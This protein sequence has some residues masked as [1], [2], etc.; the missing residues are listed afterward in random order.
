MRGRRFVAAA[1]A[2]AFLGVGSASGG[3][4]AAFPAKKSTTDPPA[5]TLKPV[6]M[7]ESATLTV[8]N[9]PFAEATAMVAGRTRRQSPP[10]FESGSV[11][12]TAVVPSVP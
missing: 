5:G 10:S 8:C 11:T 1:A 3:L 7:P 6:A 2:V 9:G 12:Y 4:V